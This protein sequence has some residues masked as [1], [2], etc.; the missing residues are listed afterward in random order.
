[1]VEASNNI[2][3]AAFNF[4]LEG[5]LKESEAKDYASKNL[6]LNMRSIF[7]ETIKGLMGSQLFIGIDENKKEQIISKY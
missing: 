7:V 6:I 1:L 3:S 4:L 2:I 5:K